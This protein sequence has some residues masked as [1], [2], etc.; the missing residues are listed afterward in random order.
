MTGIGKPGLLQ[1][2]SAPLCDDFVALILKEAK[3]LQPDTP[4]FKTSCRASSASV[5]LASIN[6]V[7]T[8]SSATPYPQVNEPPN[9]RIRS[10]PGG[11]STLYSRSRIPS[12]LTNS[13]F[14]LFPQASSL[15]ADKRVP[16]YDTTNR[17]RKNKLSACFLSSHYRSFS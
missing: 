16:C 12:E 13:T 8:S 3:L 1:L 6:P 15:S 10:V 11:L 4:V 2:K 7:K 5:N 14:T 17:N 9:T